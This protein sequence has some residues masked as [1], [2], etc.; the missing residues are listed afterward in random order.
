MPNMND[1]NLIHALLAE[2]RLVQRTHDV[3]DS[4][5]NGEMV[6]K[7]AAQRLGFDSI[8]AFDKANDDAE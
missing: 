6:A 8:E 7:L 4:I 3:R 2:L 5:I 1:E